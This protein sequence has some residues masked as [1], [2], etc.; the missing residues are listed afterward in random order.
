MVVSAQKGS[1]QM[2]IFP[3]CNKLQGKELENCFTTELQT[4]IFNNFQVSSKLK[5]SNYEGSI[6]VLFEVDDKG[7]FKVQ[8]VDANQEDLIQES[9]RVFE[10]LPKVNPPTYNGKPTY[11]KYTVKIAIPL[12]NP[13]ETLSEKKQ[14][15]ISKRL[16]TTTSTNKFDKNK[17]LKEFDSIAYQKFKNPQFQSHLNIPF[18]HSYYAQFDPA[19]NQVGSNNHTASKPYTYSEVSK[20]YN[21]EAENTKLIK[22]KKSWWGRKIWNEN[23][24]AIQGDDYWFTMNPIFDLQLGKSDPS[25]NKYTYINTRGIQLRGG[26]GNHLNF[27]STI[28]ESQGQFAD[29][30]NNYAT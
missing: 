6:I 22:N 27:T 29:Y 7:S 21:L 10:K 11:A 2:P 12:E 5:E 24:V 19:M 20:Y 1:E 26:L 14:T 15:Q 3:N 9:K 18:S 17:E 23:T 28:F 25:I 4:F 8:Y 13:A 16:T 30:Y